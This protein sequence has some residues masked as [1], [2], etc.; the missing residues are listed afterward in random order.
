MAVPK[1]GA[2]FG[3]SLDKIQTENIRRAQR[4]VL[5]IFSV[6]FVLGL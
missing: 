3:Q 5:V 2:V 6:F 4:E 1:Y